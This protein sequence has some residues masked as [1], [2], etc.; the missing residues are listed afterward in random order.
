MKPSDRS[1]HEFIEVA[2]KDSELREILLLSD[3]EVG[4]LTA[5][6]SALTP[7]VSNVCRAL[8]AKWDDLDP[9]ERAA[10]LLVLANALAEAAR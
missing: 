2:G 8:L 7:P 5:G 10:S 6:L 9:A 1:I 4:V 3:D